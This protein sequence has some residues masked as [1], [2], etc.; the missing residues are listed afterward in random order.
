MN[1]QKNLNAIKNRRIGRVRA[2]IS[3]TA[4]RPRVAVYRSNKY[5]SAQIIDDTKGVTLASA[6]SQIV[7]KK[8]AKTEGAMKVGETL[9]AAAKE[10]GIKEAVLDRRSYRFHG[11]VKAVA[12]GLK[13]GGIKI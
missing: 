4:S 2:R 9:A 12:E 6:T 1:K 5:T 7:S 10:K 11:R 13:K 3:G 8:T